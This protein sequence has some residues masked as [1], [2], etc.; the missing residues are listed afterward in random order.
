MSQIT[1]AL[2][3]VLPLVI[4]LSIFRPCQGANAIRPDTIE[5]AC[6]TMVGTVHYNIC[7]YDPTHKLLALGNRNRK[8]QKHGNWLVVEA[9]TAPWITGKYRRDRK[10]GNWWTTRTHFQVY[11]RKGRLVSESKGCR[12]CPIF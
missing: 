3:Q 4:G 6:D 5:V 11:D 10:V 2:A 1:N 12:D 9:N 7:Q 8:G